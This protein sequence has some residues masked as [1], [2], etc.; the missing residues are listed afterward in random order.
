M[1]KRGNIQNTNTDS[2]ETDVEANLVPKRNRAQRQEGMYGEIQL[3]TTDSFNKHVSI[4]SKYKVLIIG[5]DLKKA[6]HEKRI[7]KRSRQC[8][9]PW[10][11]K[12]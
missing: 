9:F 4:I 3:I 8:S 1:K 10:R 11:L 5:K 7:K 6:Q 12:N 2:R